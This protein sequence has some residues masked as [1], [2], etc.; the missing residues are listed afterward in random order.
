MNLSRFQTHEYLN[1]KPSPL[2]HQHQSPPKQPP[3]TCLH[4]VS[5]LHSVS[6]G[7]GQTKPEKSIPIDVDVHW[8]VFNGT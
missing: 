3:F 4:L 7:S 1:T 8:E 5:P 6:P 2:L